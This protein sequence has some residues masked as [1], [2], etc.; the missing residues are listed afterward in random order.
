MQE[1]HLFH[2]EELERMSQDELIREYLALKESFLEHL[3]RETEQDRLIKNLTE[4]Q[5][6][7]NAKRFGRATETSASLSEPETEKDTKNVIPTKQAEKDSDCS[8][9]ESEKKSGPD[10]NPDVRRGS[11]MGFLL[12]TFTSDSLTKN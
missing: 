8:A 1:I 3:A 7:D 11:R 4:R 10:A 12:R 2:K 6:R 5:N 9:A